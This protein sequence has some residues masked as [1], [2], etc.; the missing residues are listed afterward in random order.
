[1]V[2]DGGGA[3]TGEWPDPAGPT[4][5]AGD[6]NCADQWRVL[7]GYLLLGRKETDAHPVS[8]QPLLEPSA[9][10][11]NPEVALHEPTAAP[12]ERV[13]ISPVRTLAIPVA[14]VLVQLFH[15]WVSAK[16]LPEQTQLFSKFL[17]ILAGMGG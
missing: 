4:D 1:M 8:K 7:G 16:E 10:S 3:E 5:S 11:R 14:A 12:P 15:Q 6:R 2:E 17:W 13:R 9:P